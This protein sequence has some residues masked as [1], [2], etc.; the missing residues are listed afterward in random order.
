MTPS[1][2]QK[3]SK[4]QVVIFP[5]SAHTKRFYMDT[6]LLRVMPRSHI[7]FSRLEWSLLKCQVAFGY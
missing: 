6:C 1:H 3:L 4:R 5:S 2:T 7:T